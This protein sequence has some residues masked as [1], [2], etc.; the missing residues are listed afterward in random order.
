MVPTAEN[1]APAS[2]DTHFDVVVIGGGPGGYAS[3]L[4]GASA[5]LNVAMIE[6]QRIGGTCLHVG[7]IPAK[8]LLET[9]AVHRTVSHAKEFGVLADAPGLDFGV[10]QDRKQGVID[11][12]VDG[13][14]GLLKGR[15]VTVLD[16]TG[17]LDADHRTVHVSGG[18]SGDVSIT[19]DAVILAAGSA[20]RTIPGF[21]VDGT[22][23]VTSDE[24]LS[25]RELP[26]RAV[27]IGGGAI[28]CEFASMMSD[29]GTEVTILEALPKILPGVDKDAAQIVERSFKKR[30]ITV[31]TGVQV[32]G[33]TP[34][35]RGTTVHVDG[36]EDIET[37]MVV[38]SVGRRP[39]TD[40]L[41]LD[42]TG[43]SVD[44]RGFIEVDE[45]CRTSVD[46]VWAVGDIVP[47]AQLAH[48][49]F[50]EGMVA[51][52]D[53][54]GEDP[55][56]VDYARLPWCI[57]CHPEV[58][59]AGYS[60]EAAK[61]AGYD[62]V[63]SKHRYIGNGRAK[64]IGDTDGLV[65]VIAEKGPDGEAGR[66]LGVHMVGPWVTEQLGQAY[67]A[68]NWEAT[69]AEAAAFIQPHPT[70]S[71]NLGETLMAL[72]GRSLH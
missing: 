2:T 7:C 13:L 3:A 70:L 23:V 5:G 38:V 39:F 24:L 45:N 43:V 51:I 55:Q 61:E 17:R 35:E 36:G 8:E 62:V 4:Y 48:I 9:A 49:G 41:G 53:I 33:H 30:G 10:T 16:G 32:T 1:P 26:E 50:A 12:L 6:R 44:D 63:V 67:M 19:G 72:T 71:E 46:G 56:P 58:A 65:K 25:L 69:V 40:L 68:V 37:D 18:E 54:L 15:K 42:Q 31:E 22:L 28:G 59:F 47:T 27:V 52:R 29:L 57:Y 20:V 66:I 14:K 64:I 11:Q 34:G 21:D 60:E